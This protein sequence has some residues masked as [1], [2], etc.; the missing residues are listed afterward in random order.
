M[1]SKRALAGSLPWPSAFGRAPFCQTILNGYYR[2][3]VDVDTGYTIENHPYLLSPGMRPLFEAFRNEVTALDSKVSEEFFGT[4]VA[5]KLGTNFVDLVPQRKG[6]KLTLNVKLADID[7]SRH[8]CKD[9]SQ[10]GHLGYGD[11]G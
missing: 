2:P 11:V 8:F 4:C 3:K 5:Y 6:L 9:I 7:D 1:R 10:V